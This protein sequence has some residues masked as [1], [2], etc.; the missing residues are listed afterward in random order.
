MRRLATA[1]ALAALTVAGCDDAP[2]VGP[3]G[4]PS[5]AAAP[6]D[7]PLA[8][9][10]LAPGAPCP[11]TPARDWS[12]P[13][14]AAKVLGDGPLYPVADYFGG[15]AGLELRDSDRRPDGSYEKKARWI[16][17]GY[18]GPVLVRAARIDQPGQASVTFS[19]IGEK[20]YGGHYAE[21]T[22]AESD[23]PATTLV[24]GPGCYAY[25]VDGSTFTKVIVFR[26]DRP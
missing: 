24:G 14:V 17:A 16:G 1:L 7:R 4:S 19:Y 22:N 21:L 2:V 9:P 26:A 10:G 20:R 23:L 5:P 11:V 25:Q 15:G 6:V 12:V 13:G 8:L 3:T 18:T